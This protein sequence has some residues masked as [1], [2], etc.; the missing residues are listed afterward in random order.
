MN[1]KKPSAI[2]IFFFFI[3]GVIELSAQ[4]VKFTHYSIR[5][6]ISQ[7][8]ILCIFQDSEGFIW[9]GTQ[10]GLNKFDGY[11]FEK[12]YNDPFDSTTISSNWI[13]DITEDADGYLWIGTKRGLNKYDKKTGCFTLINHL[14]PGTMIN[15][16]FVYGLTSGDSCI[17][18]NT[19]PALSV[20]NYKTGNLETYNNQFDY[21]GALFDI[22]YPILRSSDGLLWIGSRQGLSCFDPVR[23]TFQN[24]VHHEKDPNA[25]SHNHITALYE[26]KSGSILVGTE[27]GYNIYNKKTKQF[28]RWYKDNKNNNSISNNR[29][30]SVMQDYKGA[31]WIGT[32]EGGLNKVTLYNQK[33]S[34]DFVHFATVPD[35]PGYISN[36]IVYCLYEDKS[37]NLWIG[38]IAG[39]DKLDLK[40]K[41]FNHYKKTDNPASV[42][43]LDNVVGSIYKDA[44]GKLWIGNWNKGLNIYDRKTNEV[45]HYSSSFKGRMNLPGNNVHV[46]FKDSRSLI[47]VGTRNGVSIF[48]RE[49]RSFIPF[50]DYFGVE[51]SGYFDSNRVYCILE[52]SEGKLWIG[53]GN[54]IFIMDPRTKNTMVIQAEH[55]TRLAI[56]SN[57]VYSLLED[58]D[59]YI[60]IATSSGLDRYVPEENTMYHYYRNS[61]SS[62][63]LCDNYTISLCEDFTGNIWIGTS[64]G[65]SKFNKTD[66]TYTCYTMKEGLPSNIIYGIIEDNHHDLWFATGNG[67][68]RYNA[69]LGT[70]R[71]YTLEEGVQGMEFN[72]NAMFKGDDGELFF[73]CIDGF[74]SFFPDSLKDNPYLPPLKITS[75][76]KENNG[77][78]SRMSV[79]N[80][81]IK[82][83]YRDYS[84]TI[85]FSAL[86]YSAPLKNQYAYQ[87]EPLSDK[88][89]DI[90]NR[91]FVHFTNLPPGNYIFRV[92][93][94]NNDGIWSNSV[95][96]I[97]INIAPPW[98]KSKYALVSYILF[99]TMA[100]IFTIRWRLTKLV[101]EKKLLEQKVQ[102]RT[103]EIVR[104]KDKLN[105]LN[106]TKD[107][108]FSILAHDLKGPFSSLYSVS[109]VL[110]GNYDNMEE[111]EKRTGLNKIHK[112]AELI[113]KLLENLL[114]WSRSQR[115]GMEFSPVK[116]SL[117]RLVEVNVNLHKVAAK[118]KQIELRNHVKDDVFV[119]GDSEMINSVIRN[120]ISNAVKYTPGNKTVE[121]DFKEQP[122]LCE[123]LVKDQGVGISHENMQKLF[124]IDVKYKTTGTAGEAGTGLGLVLCREFVEKNGGKIWC[125]SQENV[126]TIFHFTIPREG[127]S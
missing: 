7:S 60:W 118:E 117:S 64:T 122:G 110:T 83:S 17:Y 81:M 63:T 127:I 62:N 112:L 111:P 101:K 78:K 5:E 31:I 38:T 126:G 75:F 65:V 16:V 55:T 103:E 19:P 28:N 36:D 29:I 76:E 57:L 30:R 114:T 25:I 85:E 120:L 8:V 33:G 56:S 44:E 104:Q 91:R 82:L 125:E 100:V 42:D 48:N 97:T 12:Y 98:W 52:D 84:F 66:S 47:W 77:I 53:T 69:D 87:L 27:D 24:F 21:E 121:V 96:S 108:F 54:G 116:F 72:I 73:G 37:H 107:K 93:G 94:T 50:Q 67:L 26:N 9:F 80:D 10:N 95:A 35:N 22:G 79:Y 15:D 49:T 4:Q 124:R 92:K 20:F 41:K 6:G 34:A 115:G 90:G 2:L 14:L 11:T 123:V 113:Y 32:E 46:I 58:R 106:S 102:E 68:A 109:E 40:E 3:C 70:I 74:I 13:F 61:R 59:R 89:I 18:I 119:F 1:K 71:P 51:D 86:D 99:A 105:E 43:L 39:M 45:L 23:K 88:W